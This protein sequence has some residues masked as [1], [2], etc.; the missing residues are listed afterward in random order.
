[1]TQSTTTEQEA[2]VLLSWYEEGDG[3]AQG[4]KAPHNW[5]LRAES[6]LRRLNSY[7]IEL[8]SEAQANARIIGASAENELALRAR[9][10]E[11]QRRVAKLEKT[12][13]TRHRQSKASCVDARGY[14]LQHAEHRKV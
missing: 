14:F 2:L 13:C 11:L 3:F 9:V 8:E 12:F 1:M 6:E 5:V 7:V 10:Q 4:T